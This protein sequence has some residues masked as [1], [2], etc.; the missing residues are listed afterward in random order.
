MTAAVAV[1]S[2]RR[3]LMVL[4]LLG[5]AAIAAILRGDLAASVGAAAEAPS[6]T[7]EFSAGQRSTSFRV[8]T[9]DG[10]VFVPVRLNG[11]PATHWF[12]LDTGASRMLIERKLAQELAIPLEGNGSIGGAG[13]GRVPVEFARHVRFEVPGLTM[14]ESELAATD[15]T[16]LESIVGRPIEGIIGYEFFLSNVVAVDYEANT[17]T[18]TAP[19]AFMPPKNAEELPLTFDK[20]WVRVKA[21]L[22][23]PGLPP[24]EDDFLV[25]SGS[26]DAANHPRVADAKGRETVDG[27]N[28]LGQSA[29]AFLVRAESLRLGKFL[30]RGA[31]AVSTNSNP[32][33]RGLI[34]AGVLSQFHVIYDYPGRRMFL[35][36]NRF[37][38]P[39]SEPQTTR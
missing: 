39:A 21:T 10:L 30:L 23:L 11:S 25:D 5:V 12:V 19:D 2:A 29:P 14:T 8:E 37:F 26:N 4:L 33:I 27:G 3:A 6:P 28:G 9:L 38:T 35:R 32:D 7:T 34:G 18:V 1:V 22:H 17:L 20:K 24:V 15:L 31:N 13:S 36:P 16:A